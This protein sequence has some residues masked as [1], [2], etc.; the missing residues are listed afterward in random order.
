M[1]GVVLVRSCFYVELS[2]EKMAK[3]AL[4]NVETL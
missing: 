1:V 4:C 3:V 2:M